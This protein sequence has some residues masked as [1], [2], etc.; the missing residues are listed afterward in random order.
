MFSGPE[1]TP[2]FGRRKVRV[3]LVVC[4]GLYLFV[5]CAAY[6]ARAPVVPERSFAVLGPEVVE[7]G[8]TFPIRVVAYRHAPRGHVASEVVSA[9]IDDGL[10]ERSVDLTEATPGT[11]SLAQIQSAPRREGPFTLKLTVRS[12]D[13]DR[14]IAVPMAV[15]YPKLVQDPPLLGLQ[16]QIPEGPALIVEILPEGDGLALALPNRVWLRVTDRTGK[17]AS[18]AVLKWTSKG[19]DPA[20]GRAETDAAGLADITVTPRS[21]APRFMVTAERDGAGG[22]L[23]ETHNASGAGALI[24]IDRML[25]AQGEPPHVVHVIRADPAGPV[26]CDLYRGDAW[27]RNW[28]LLGG[29]GDQRVTTFEVDQPAADNYRVQCYTHFAEPGE[30]TDSAWL[31]SRKEARVRAMG[32]LLRG[33]VAST[34][35]GRTAQW[36]RQVPIIDEPA[37]RALLASYRT[38]SLEYKTPSLVAGTRKADVEA[39]TQANRRIRVRFFIMIAL[40]FG[41]IILWALYTAVQTAIENRTRLAEEIADLPHDLVVDIEPPTGLVRMRTGVQ[42]AFI[43]VVLVLNV[44]A[45]LELF[46]HM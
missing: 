41:L 38:R 5:L 11:P 21:L 4:V 36:R 22:R 1:K 18:G 16:D 46:K 24:R 31:F 43:T 23:E 29:D 15:Y 13:V 39:A 19:T 17:P 6:M 25:R 37:S 27:V 28:H 33:G 9:R 26:W 8:G 44:L 3:G 20:E 34:G 7:P 45:M 14:E 12:E 40:S 35:P 10:T 30:G 42:S 2:L 32:E